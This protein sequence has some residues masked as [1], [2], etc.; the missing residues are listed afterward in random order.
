[1]PAYEQPSHAADQAHHAHD[2]LLEFRALPVVYIVAQ[3]RVYV[4]KGFRL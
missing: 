2:V 3:L 1:M 4:L